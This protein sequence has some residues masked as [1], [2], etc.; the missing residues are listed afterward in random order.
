MMVKTHHHDFFIGRFVRRDDVTLLFDFP[1]ERLEPVAGRQES[2]QKEVLSISQFSSS[3]HHKSTKIPRKRV[4]DDARKFIITHHHSLTNLCGCFHR[5]C[6]GRR[7]LKVFA[8]M[9]RW[10]GA[11]L[12]ALCCCV[13]CVRSEIITTETPRTSLRRPET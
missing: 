7:P 5:P 10:L 13:M 12:P 4:R 6:R 11:P 3:H 1:A 2:Q 9:T 8:G